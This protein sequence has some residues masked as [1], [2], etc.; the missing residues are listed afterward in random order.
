MPT[1][2]S[3]STDHSAKTDRQGFE[4]AEYRFGPLLHPTPATK[5]AWTNYSI[6]R[7]QTMK[8][9]RAVLP[10]SRKDPEDGSE[11]DDDD[12]WDS[13]I[14]DWLGDSVKA[15]VSRIE[16]EMNLEVGT[17]QK[18]IVI[19]WDCTDLYD[20]QPRTTDNIVRIYSP[21]T[22]MYIDVHFRYH[23]RSRWSEVEWFYALGYKIQHRPRATVC[24]ARAF[25]EELVEG[26]PPPDLHTRNGWQNICWGY[27]DESNGNY[28]KK[29]RR[30]ELAKMELYEEGVMD[31]YET[32]FGEL[33]RPAET[34]SEAMLAYRRSL[35]RG[36][37][38]L[39][40]A[41]GIS[42]EVA[43]TDEEN[44]KRPPLLMLEGHRDTWVGRG[45]RNACGIR[46]ARDAEEEREGAQERRKEAKGS[47]NSYDDFEH[48]EHHRSEDDD[49]DY[50]F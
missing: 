33:E 45:I 20:S 50:G 11:E 27:F 21:T 43:C 30:V 13:E 4:L 12:G 26:A 25:K 35:V 46:L 8:K 3:N 10:V 24:D 31:V 44:D 2:S 36:I 23:C 15:C 37:R 1:G 42:Y 22:P 48:D 49:S 38:L 39:L 19:L 18:C 5:S 40:A 7:L 29:W 16:K 32:L 9:Y 47:N 14:E 34:D 28:G 17:L 6:N 41:A